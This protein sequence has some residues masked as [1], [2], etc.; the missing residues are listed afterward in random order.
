MRMHTAY[1]EGLLA[2]LAGWESYDCPY[3]EYARGEN[4]DRTLWLSGWAK[5]NLYY[6]A[7]NYYIDSLAGEGGEAT[8]LAS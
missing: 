2:G 5:G 1:Q 8:I 7:L 6:K 4:R 3:P